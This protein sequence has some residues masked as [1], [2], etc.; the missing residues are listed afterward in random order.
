MGRGTSTTRGGMMFGYAP[1]MISCGRTHVPLETRMIFAVRARDYEAFG[2]AAL[3]MFGNE[4]NGTITLLTFLR[5]KISLPA[6]SLP[7]ASRDAMMLISNAVLDRAHGRIE[8]QI[9]TYASRGF[10][11]V[12]VEIDQNMI[13]DEVSK[14]LDATRLRLLV[15]RAE[16]SS[17]FRFNSPEQFY[18]K[19]DWAVKDSVDAALSRAFHDQAEAFVN[20][21]G[22][23]VTESNF[24]APTRATMG[25]LVRQGI[26][27]GYDDGKIRMSLTNWI[28]TLSIGVQ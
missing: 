1:R 20:K 7:T 8:Q 24:D 21:L 4:T 25:R 13:V 12:G 9:T 26:D 3:E 15:S 5:E 18:E 6:D 14:T 16:S 19:I 11:S 28:D 27:A 2:E 10:K 22:V 17:A 23:K